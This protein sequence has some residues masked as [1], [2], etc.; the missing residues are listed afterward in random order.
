MLIEIWERL[1][2]YDKW[3][4]TDATIQSSRLTDVEVGEIRGRGGPRRPVIASESD[5]TIAWTDANGEKHTA[6]YEVFEDSPL[7]QLYEGQTVTIRYNP[8]DP[9]QF[10]LRG[11]LRSQIVTRFSWRLL[12]LLAILV[13]LLFFL[14]LSIP[15][16]H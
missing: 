14:F 1:R 16:R 15:R 2:G 5:C 3:L 10:Y 8:A 12:P 11:V 13:Y 6:V 4:E 9:D 7:Y